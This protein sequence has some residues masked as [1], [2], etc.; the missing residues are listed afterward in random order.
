MIRSGGDLVR[1]ALV[2]LGVAVVW[3]VLFRLNAVLFAQFE[4]SSRA[5]WV[6]LPAAVRVLSVLLFQ[7]AGAAGLML[8]AFFTLPHHGLASLL[9]D[10]L[11]SASSAIAPLVS[12]VICRRWIGLAADLSGL[13]GLHIVAVSVMS[14]AVNAVGLNTAL[15]AVGQLK[16]D[17][18]QIATVFVG[19][20]L[21]SAIVLA[22]ISLAL[23]AFT[24]R[25]ARGV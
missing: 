23:S 14:A 24:R 18:P 3:A 5:H 13:R 8:G 7:G 19:D 20:M 22:L 17:M 21:G 6:F 9:V 10:L 11:I 15:A 1:K 2:V 25:A 16:G 12:V 4:H